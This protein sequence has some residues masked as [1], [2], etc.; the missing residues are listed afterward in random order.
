MSKQKHVLRKYIEFRKFS[1]TL[2]ICGGYTLNLAFLNSKNILAHLPLALNICISMHSSLIIGSEA[3]FTKGRKAGGGAVSREL[4]LMLAAETERTN[5]LQH[6]VTK[7]KPSSS[8]SEW[9]NNSPLEFQMFHARD[10]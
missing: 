2:Q 1:H 9:N 8:L 5:C 7:I 10:I 4:G 3:V 6:H